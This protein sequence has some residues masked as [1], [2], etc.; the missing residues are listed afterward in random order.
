[1]EELIDIKPI[2]DSIIPLSQQEHALPSLGELPKRPVDAVFAPGMGPVAPQLRSYGGAALGERHVSADFW[3]LREIPIAIAELAAQGCI[4]SNGAIVLSGRATANTGDVAKALESRLAENDTI[5][6]AQ[7]AV[8][9]SDPAKAGA[10]PPKEFVGRYSVYEDFPRAY[11]KPATEE[12]AQKVRDTTEASLMAGLVRRTVPKVPT[13]DRHPL[14]QDILEDPNAKNTIDNVI[15]YLNL[16]DK[17]SGGVWDGTTAIVSPNFGQM[18]RIIELFQAFGVRTNSLVPLGAEQILK[19][20]GYG[21][22]ELGHYFERFN[23]ENSMP[24]TI[25]TQE[26]WLRAV[27]EEPKYILELVA[28][29]TND[30]RLKMVMTSLEQ[31]YG[32]DLLY[33]AHPSLSSWRNADASS[34]RDTLKSIKRVLPGEEL[35]QHADLTNWDQQNRYI[36]TVTHQWMKKVSHG[37]T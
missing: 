4:D 13:E 37:S 10:I 20:S 29:F 22:G 35:G 1:M 34:L 14:T 28:G 16:M 12:E 15:Q 32:K 3:R 6:V 27:R 18:Q 30:E 11:G 8:I 19:S 23:T 17:R 24:N 9:S 5:L 25:K 21:E 7:H 2:I 33:Q 26:R 31:W 36:D